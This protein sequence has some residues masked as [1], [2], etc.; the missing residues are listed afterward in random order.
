[1]EKYSPSRWSNE[2]KE[3]QQAY[4]I[5]SLKIYMYACARSIEKL[6]LSQIDRNATN[7]SQ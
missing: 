2:G 5:K 4:Q 7:M 3:L 6:R 1:M